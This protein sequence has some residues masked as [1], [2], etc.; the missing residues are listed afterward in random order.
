MPDAPIHPTYVRLLR[1]LLRRL[2]ADADALLRAAG[3]TPAQLAGDAAPLP[4]DAVA[5]LAVASMR[6]TA[7]PWLGLELGASIEPSSHGALGLAVITSP[8]LREAV[9]AIARHA[10]TRGAMLRWR[11]EEQ[12]QQATLSIAPAVPLGEAEGFILDVVLA[13]LLRALSAVAGDLAG[14][15]V[16]I[17]HPRPAWSAQYQALSDAMFTFDATTLSLCFPAALLHTPGLAADAAAHAAALR[18]C[19]ATAHAMEGGAPSAVAVVE[20]RLRAVHDG[21]YP[22]LQQLAHELGCSART[23]MRR[24]AQ[25][26]TS[27]QRLLDAARQD[28]ALWY[29]QHTSASVEEIAHA[30]GYEDASN[31]GRTCRRWFGQAPSRLRAPGAA[32]SRAP[33]GRARS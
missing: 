14:L 10:S 8:R 3:I 1:M 27:F 20:R 18:E 21:A 32:T 16:G 33:A 28:R 19:E 5:R 26:D 2:G 4:L 22:G 6:L 30:L 12:P 31:F 7:R 17:P 24:L 25:E 9:H 13:C 11:L 23:L 29:L 15:H